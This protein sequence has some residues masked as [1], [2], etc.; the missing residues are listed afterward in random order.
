MQIFDASTRLPDGCHLIEASAGT[1]KTY[2]VMTL[3]VRAIAIDGL[4]PEAVM[5]TTFTKASTRELRARLRT[6]FI[7][8]LG[9]LEAVCEG[10][11]DDIETQRQRLSKALAEIQTI[12]IDT[13]HSFASQVI[14]T[15]GPL[16]GVHPCD[17]MED[18]GTLRDGIA[19]ETYRALLTEHD[20]LWVRRCLGS[21]ATFLKEIDWLQNHR[22][23]QRQP[24]PQGIMDLKADAAERQARVDAIRARRHAF[25][26][27]SDPNGTLAK[28][29]DHYEAAC[30]EGSAPSTTAKNYLRKTREN[31]PTGPWDEYEALGR[32]T[33]A[34]GQ[35][36]AYAIE[37]FFNRLRAMLETQGIRNPDALIDDALQI[38]LQVPP[39]VLANS[40]FA[41]HQLIA[42]DEFQDTDRM[43][44]ALLT[45][46]YPP[47]P[48]R[49]MILIGD[50][51]QTI[52][53]FRGADTSQYTRIRDALPDTHRWTLTDVYR[54]ADSVV[55]GLNRLFSNTSYFGS[56]I[57][58]PT[59]SSGAPHNHPALR[60]DD[61]PLSG[62]QWL[63][64]GD[65]ETVAEAVACVLGLGQQG[66]LQLYDANS[67]C[68]TPVMAHHLCVLSRDR[69]TAM[70]VKQAA[71]QRGIPMVYSD[72]ITVFQR[73]IVQDLGTLLAAIAN[74]HNPRPLTEFL[75]TRWMNLTFTPEP[76]TTR[77]EFK[78]LQDTCLKAQ[79]LWFQQGPARAIQAAIADLQ[80]DCPRRTLGGLSDATDLLHALEHF[81]ENGK[82]LTP[83][84]AVRWWQQQR[85]REDRDPK[86]MPRTPTDQSLVVINTIHGAKGLEYP[87]VFVAGD[88][89]TKPRRS[90]AYAIDYVDPSSGPVLDFTHSPDAEAAKQAEEEA[91]LRRLAYVALTR[92]KF[93]VFLG[94]STDGVLGALWD[95]INPTHLGDHHA[96][97]ELPKVPVAPLTLTDGEQS[98]SLNQPIEPHWLQTSFSQL[99]HRAQSDGLPNK[100]SDEPDDLSVLQGSRTSQGTG[101]HWHALPGG[102]DTGNLLHALLEDRLKTPRTS[103]EQALWL[104]SH[105]PAS[106]AVEHQATVLAW[107]DAVLAHPI[108]SGPLCELAPEDRRPE[109]GFRL[110]FKAGLTVA[111]LCTGC[112]RIDWMPP[113][114]FGSN[115]PLARQL[116]GFID[117]IFFRDGQFHLLDYKTNRLGETDAAYTDEALESSMQDGQY[118]AQALLYALALHHWLRL[119]LSDYDPYVHLGQIHYL[120]CRGLHGPSRGLWSRP[121][122]VDQVIQLSEEWI[123]APSH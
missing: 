83:Y 73:P 40:P 29:L 46:L 23:A 81:G 123:D 5:L 18:L 9:R 2:T 101:T 66:R 122:P 113:L 36:R 45:A 21:M 54:S 52:Y 68:W 6:R 78:Q 107:A 92:A 89:Q 72:P 96:I 41:A 80:L 114:N 112:A 31:H 121:I 14:N 1:G 91:E 22:H 30:L 61:Q 4:P 17:A 74:P 90:K 97:A 26:D 88:F 69:T 115:R 15:L 55:Q 13:I 63:H 44:W 120:F 32:P 103:T 28:H 75:A 51:K 95:E 7:E 34:E 3:V 98:P 49:R 77:P 118:P 86:T 71:A 108:D 65:S 117:L 43:Q 64:D 39:T 38:A 10:Q 106:L 104:Q 100:A 109:P 102:T 24:A 8:E 94:Q 111:D 60:L 62:F 27:I 35:F 67:A 37:T 59:L 53:R 99:T 11:S 58:M 82:G 105:W 33:Q 19:C 42:V 119:R 16:V 50:P 70:H 110:T 84:E 47:H 85:Q 93:A 76:L 12:G 48:G 116:N 87:I 25:A 20:P 56:G 79:R 57:T